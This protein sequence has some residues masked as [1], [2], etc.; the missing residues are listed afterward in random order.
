MALLFPAFFCMYHSISH[1]PAADSNIDRFNKA[2]NVTG[3]TTYG[4]KGFP[5]NYMMQPKQPLRHQ[6]SADITSDVNR[7]FRKGR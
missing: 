3:A 2:Y 7:Y 1:I 6:P 4:F 5:D